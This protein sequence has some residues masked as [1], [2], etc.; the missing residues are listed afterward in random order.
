MRLYLE[1]KQIQ[2]DYMKVTK[3]KHIV[4][5]LAVGTILAGLCI[6]SI[7]FNK[8]NFAYASA[9]EVCTE[10]EDIDEQVAVVSS[11]TKQLTGSGT[12]AGPYLIYDSTDLNDIR[13]YTVYNSANR[14]YIITGYFQLKSTINLSG[15]WTPFEYSFAGTFDGNGYSIHNLTVAATD[16]SDN[17]G[18]FGL[19][20]GTI[21]NL[22]MYNFQATASCDA[23]ASVAVG[24]VAGSNTGT[25]SNCY[26]YSSTI[27]INGKYNSYVGGIVAVVPV[28]RLADALLIVVLQ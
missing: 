5:I 3:Q 1:I 14:G 2:E 26:L 18:L 9:D 8:V 11:T 15:T 23:T 20:T 28:E 6:C 7:G 16:D 27:N 19:N 17:W 13:N 24:A 25:I 22:Y 10:T 4:G 21:K 12:A